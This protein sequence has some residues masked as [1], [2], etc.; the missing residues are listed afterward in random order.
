MS[1][2]KLPAAEPVGTEDPETARLRRRARQKADLVRHVVTFVI[3]GAMLAALDVLTSPGDLWFYWPMG[4][5]GIGLL[6]HVADVYLTGEGTGL[7]E[8]ILRHEIERRH[9]ARG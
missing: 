3:I 1:D 2:T 5:W 7:D 8:R 4:A 9:H 6:L